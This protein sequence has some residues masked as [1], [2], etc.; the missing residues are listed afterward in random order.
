MSVV[1]VLLVGA[2]FGEQVVDV[3]YLALYFDDDGEGE[4]EEE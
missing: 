3:A 1:L 2:D 4:E